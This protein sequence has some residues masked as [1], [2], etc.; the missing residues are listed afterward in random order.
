VRVL[1]TNRPDHPGTVI[2]KDPDPNPNAVT[3]IAYKENQ[4]VVTLTST[5][6]F[7]T[8]GFLADV[9]EVF[10]RHGVVID[11]ISTSEVSVSVTTFDRERLEPALEQL[12][13]FGR[14]ETT[15]GKTIL[16][17][18]G[19]HLAQRPGLGAKIL[20]AVADTGV[21]VEMMSYGMGSINFTMLIDDGDIGR[22]VPVLH[23]VLFERE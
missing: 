6:M 19:Q 14:I 12:R 16:V 20:N 13:G 10:K 8:A 7:G 23:E 3:S 11:M 5:R 21:N 18:V 4:T 15:P 17:V 1:N 22:A 2:Q 9:F